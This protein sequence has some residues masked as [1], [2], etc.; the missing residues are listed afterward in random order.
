M[1]LFTRL[2]QRFLNEND[3]SN[4]CHIK[5]LILLSKASGGL[6]EQESRI[7]RTIAENLYMP[8][9][10]VFRIF[11]HLNDIPFHVPLSEKRK[12]DQMYDLVFLL[13]LRNK[14]AGL[15]NDESSM[16]IKM[17]TLKY[18]FELNMINNLKRKIVESQFWKHRQLDI[19]KKVIQNQIRYN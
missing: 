3:K 12:F 4:N 19:Q 7:I 1:G 14:S 17:I 8:N 5:N 16:I 11:K 2:Q 10:S 6:G 18:G 15:E 9:D 13:L